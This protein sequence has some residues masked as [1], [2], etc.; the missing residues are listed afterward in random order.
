M[1]RYGLVFTLAILL[2]CVGSAFAADPPVV[3]A[4]EIVGNHKIEKDAIRT[5]IKTQIGSYEEAIAAKDLKI[6]NCVP[7]NIISIL[8]VL[9]LNAKLFYAIF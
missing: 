4:I 3:K 8:F 6:M 2:L 9:V 5:K 1:R 7:Q